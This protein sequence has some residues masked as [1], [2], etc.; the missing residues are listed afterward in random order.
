[1]PNNCWTVHEEGLLQLQRW[2][3]EE[4]MDTARLGNSLGKGTPGSTTAHRRRGTFSPLIYSYWA[5]SLGIKW[6]PKAS[7]HT[8]PRELGSFSPEKKRLRG[9]YWPLQFSFC[10][11]L[12]TGREVMDS[13]RARGGSGWILG[14]VSYQ[15]EWW[16]IGTGSPGWVVESSSLEVVKK[17]ADVALTDMLSG[18]GGNGL[19]VGLHDLSDLLQT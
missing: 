8:N 14:K 17:H 11:Y 2:K 18:H 10:R 6:F 5:Q 19:M 3:P 9:P 1:M 7:V 4:G 16:Y 15:K 13:S 12:A